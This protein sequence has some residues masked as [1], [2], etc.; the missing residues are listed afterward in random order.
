[1][2]DAAREASQ[3]LETLKNRCK[4]AGL[5]VSRPQDTDVVAAAGQHL[6][7]AETHAALAMLW[8]TQSG[9]AHGYR[10]TGQAALTSPDL[11]EAVNDFQPVTWHW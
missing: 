5:D 3:R 2:T 4:G 9:Y 1:V 10:W 11:A 6:P 8:P 7:V